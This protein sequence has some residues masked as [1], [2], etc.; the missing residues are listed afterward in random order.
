MEIILG[1]LL[2][3]LGTAIGIF[4]RNYSSEKGKNLA[5]KED[6]GAITS[7]VERVKAD[8][9]SDLAKLNSTLSFHEKH[10]SNVRAKE[11]EAVLSFYDAASKL[12]EELHDIPEFFANP[13]AQAEYESRRIASYFADLHSRFYKARRALTRMYI[14]F[15]PEKQIAVLANDVFIAAGDLFDFFEESRPGMIEATAS[16]ITST[17]GEDKS[18]PLE[19]MRKGIATASKYMTD[20]TPL[21]NAYKGKLGAF[22]NELHDYFHEI[23]ASL[24]SPS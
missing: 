15:R 24:Q 5:T 6:I 17:S 12:E 11:F 19:I 18:V 23:S 20:L 13:F 22:S 21:K 4:I 16:R 10:K 8:F 14:Y 1:G 7:A 3:L 9:S 2:V